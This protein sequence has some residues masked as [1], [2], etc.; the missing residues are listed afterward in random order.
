MSTDRRFLFRFGLALLGML[1]LCL[2]IFVGLGWV[3]SR[4]SWLLA[5]VMSPK[6]QDRLWSWYAHASDGLAPWDSD[7]DGFSDGLELFYGTDSRNPHNSPPFHVSNIYIDQRAS[8]IGEWQHFILRAETGVPGFSVV[9]GTL[10]EISSPPSIMHFRRHAG[11]P[12]VATLPIRIGADGILEFDFTFAA[13]ID[14]AARISA[15]VVV[16]NPRNGNAYP[17][18][19]GAVIAGWR[20]PAIPATFC[21]KAGNPII[22]RRDA[23]RYSY[24]DDIFVKPPL[25]DGQACGYE[26]EGHH[27]N[28]GWRPCCRTLYRA[29]PGPVYHLGEWWL[30]T[31]STCVADWDWSII[32]ILKAPPA[33]GSPEK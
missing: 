18:V 4:Q 25:D 10:L 3:V 27:K 30:P 22:P 8:F 6:S 31:V 20:G 14:L 32:P 12:A 16:T 1:A 23:K 5:K 21:D 15:P 17:A 13:A 9:P 11:D 29:D 33:A 2:F 19:W 7:G 28:P 24:P 26:L